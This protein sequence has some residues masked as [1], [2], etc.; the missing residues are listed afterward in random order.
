MTPVSSTSQAILCKV[1]NLAS[2]VGFHCVAVYGFNT[3]ELRRDLWSY[4]TA[5]VSSIDG[6]ILMGGDLNAVLSPEDRLNGCPVTM[7]EVQDFQFCLQSTGLT[8]VRTV[9][10]PYTW[11][12][13]KEGGYRICSQIGRVVVNEDWFNLF[14]HVVVE[15]QERSVSDHCP[16]FLDLGLEMVHRNTPFRF[17]NV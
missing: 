8:E 4:L 2:G 6:P 10:G 7:A 11:S 5:V 3:I 12:N 1:V 14:S 17:L 16:L 9:G 13:N 15:L